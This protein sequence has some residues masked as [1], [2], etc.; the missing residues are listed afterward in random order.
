MAVFEERALRRSKR[1]D[2]LARW[3]IGAG[4]VLVIASVL[5]IVVFILSQAVPLFLPGRAIP[6][7]R[8]SLPGGRAE[9][10]AVAVGVWRAPGAE[11]ALA[12]HI[13]RRGNVVVGRPA[14]GEI[15][16][17]E[18]I[19][20]P[21]GRPGDYI[22]AVE[23]HTGRG[24]DPSPLGQAATA[25]AQGKVESGRQ[26]TPRY[27]LL[28]NSGA[29]SLVEL[30][31]LPGRRSAGGL[32]DGVPTG[33]AD[34]SHAVGDKLVVELR[35]H[36]APSP[37][38]P[39]L[40]VA[41]QAEVKHGLASSV[42]FT[43]VRLLPGNRLEI[44]REIQERNFL[45]QVVPRKRS[46]MI[47]ASELGPIMALGMDRSGQWLYA[48]T[49]RGEL[50]RW[51]LGQDARVV[52]GEIVSAFDDGRA[53][54]ALTLLA[55]DVSLAV[56][57]SQG[58]VTFWFPAA[59]PEGRPA[60][61]RVHTLTPHE[62]P[63]VA[64][65]PSARDKSV[66]SLGS[67]GQASLLHATTER[68][69]VQ[70]SIPGTT[71]GLADLA[72]SGNAAVGLGTDGTLYGWHLKA[73]HPEASWQA[74]FGRVHYEGYPAPAFTWQSGGTDDYEPKLSVVPL[75]FGTLKAT[76]YAMVFALPVALL[77]AV[78]TSQ[79][80]AP[81][82]RRAIKPVVELMAALP[83]VV[84]GFLAA[85]WLAPLVERWIVAMFLAVAV[86]PLVFGVFLAL[87]RRVRGFTIAR[88]LERGGEFLATIPVLLAAWALGSWLAGPVESWL[89]GGSFPLWL[90]QRLGMQYDIR[91][92]LVVGLGLGFAVIPIIF[93][94]AEDA[95]AAVPAHLTAA[96]MALGATRWQTVWRVVLPSA[97]PGIFAAAMIGFGRAVGETMIVLMAAGNTPILDWSPFNGMRTL[98]ANIAIEIPEAPVGGTLYRVLFLCAVLLFLMTFAL[99]TAAELV[100]Q[101]L[102]R[103]FGR[104]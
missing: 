85:L 104:V 44:T 35:G 92:A 49:Q 29:V 65:V 79:F 81:G 7:G 103:R 60:L 55:G 47:E 89:F 26:V 94:L 77:A 87:W 27:T 70:L 25:D 16:A 80:A 31:V 101:A 5:G 78:Y 66:L 93:S 100:R 58:Q 88:R 41:R 43:A 8:F 73:P 28:W 12:W 64:L 68:C 33:G 1:R 86:F 72:A 11:D 53:I 63:V 39:L 20:P 21:G 97:S 56:G 45:G 36:V 19:K 99:N 54:T 22:H 4:G 74:L 59:G 96:S 48:G 3:A 69:L 46:A 90:H 32:E 2:R 6:A 50:A 10:P 83:S 15:L 57:D 9:D 42:Q 18:T 82:L 62:G 34:S 95:L 67:D 24:T 13:T 17:R 14:T 76:A 84:V 91:N 23:R 40:A 71:L 37:Q 52:F 38:R 98:A 61:Q 51:Q 75:L 30:V 102:R